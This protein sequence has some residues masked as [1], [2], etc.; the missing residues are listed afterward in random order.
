MLTYKEAG[1]DIEA[2]NE[3]VSRIKMNCDSVGHFAGLYPIGNQ[4]LV[5]GADGVGT[6]LKIA[7]ELGKHDTVGIDL[8]AMCV[9]DILTLGATPLFFLDYYATSKLDVDQ[10]EKVLSGIMKGC[11]LAQC[12]LLGGETAEMPGF[13]QPSEYDLSGFAVGIVDKDKVIDGQKIVA[14]DKLVALPSSGVHS[15][16]FSLIHKVLESRALPLEELLTPTRIYTSEIRQLTQQYSVK[17]MAHVTGG[18]LYENTKRSIPSDLDIEINWSAWT[19]PSIF[20]SIQ[21]A[22]NI[23]IEEMRRVFNMG[24]GMV[25][26]VEE[27]T[28]REIDLPCIG[29]VIQ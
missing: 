15:N 24:I 14:G 16:G 3:L 9:N 10:A 19:P 17:G 6:K 23:H 22:G 20:N 27:D 5:A 12:Q 28:A 11:E 29:E 25:L 13:Y 7:F 1:V 8:V 26:I 4:Y 2:G 18:G 21:E